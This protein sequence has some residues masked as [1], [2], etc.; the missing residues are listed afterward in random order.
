MFEGKL[1]GIT[2]GI[3]TMLALITGLYAVNVKKIGIIAAILSMVIA[4]PLSDAYSI[5]ATEKSSNRKKAWE[6]GVDAFLSQFI[7][8]FG[9]LILIIL[10]PTVDMGLVLSYIA[11]ITITI[12]YGIYR[13][14]TWIEILK[15]LG[16]IFSLI[17][18]TYLSEMVVKYYFGE[19]EKQEPHKK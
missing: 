9:F 10:S 3:I 8:Q 5:Y 7:L 13:A 16:W 6:I 15:N 2:N 4:D 17:I 19:E 11:G 1:F 18:V 14:V 12:G